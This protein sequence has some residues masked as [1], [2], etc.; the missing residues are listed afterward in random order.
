MKFHTRMGVINA[1]NGSTF[2]ICITLLGLYSIPFTSYAN[3]WK[4]IF[5]ALFTSGLFLGIFAAVLPHSMIVSQSVY[6]FFQFFIRINDAN[7]TCC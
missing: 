2:L 6:I 4:K 5:L 7:K 1:A 3:T